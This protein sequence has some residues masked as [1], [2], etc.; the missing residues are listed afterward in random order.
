MS[1]CVVLIDKDT[2]EAES[3]VASFSGRMFETLVARNGQEG[4]K[5]VY[6]R[7][8]DLI[9]LDLASCDA[10]PWDTLTFLR[11]LADTPVVVL[12]S[13]CE[14]DDLIKSFEL[15]A[16]DYL[17]RPFT[18]RALTERVTAVLRRSLRCGAETPHGR[19]DDGN[20]RVEMDL[21]QV[22]RRGEQV[23]L[24]RTE[25]RLVS[26][27]LRRPGR[28]ITHDELLSEVW[29]SQPNEKARARLT[30]YV[31]YLREKLED[32]PERPLYIK[33]R[34]GRGYTFEP[35]VVGQ[36][37]WAGSPTALIGTSALNLA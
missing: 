37:A 1:P 9:V 29:G 19:Y 2:T 32:D 5:L 15:G 13:S 16:D 20:L 31:R 25:F 22:W 27:L 6:A 14:E 18:A 23:S 26:A 12:S 8:P 35:R 21:Q 10:N 28:V 33:T 4:L 24:T 7:R 3:C 34:W 36:T 17:S 11:D 30:L